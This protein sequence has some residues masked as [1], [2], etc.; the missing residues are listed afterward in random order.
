MSEEKTK[1]KKY[2]RGTY[3]IGFAVFLLI[4]ILVF[5]SDFERIFRLDKD[6]EADMVNEGRLCF[7][8]HR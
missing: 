3:L 4:A 6:I 8:G 2:Y 7:Y 1:L 5:V